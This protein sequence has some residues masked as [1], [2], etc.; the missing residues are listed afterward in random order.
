MA[1]GGRGLPTP[2]L[3]NSINVIQQ[4]KLKRLC[5]F[6]VS[7]FHTKE[8]VTKYNADFPVKFISNKLIICKDHANAALTSNM[9]Y[10]T[11]SVEAKELRVQVKLIKKEQ[12]KQEIIS[13]IDLEKDKD[14]G[15]NETVYEDYNETQS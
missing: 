14:K 3:L 6:C 8:I 11:L 15:L 2:L 9:P 12:I 4:L 1:A 7:V 5:V 13:E 10:G